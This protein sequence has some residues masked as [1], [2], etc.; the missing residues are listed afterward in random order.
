MLVRSVT[1]ADVTELDVHLYLRDMP[2]LL[3]TV[4]RTAQ[5]A[6][7]VRAFVSAHKSP[8]D[9]PREKQVSQRISQGRIVSS[10]II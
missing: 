5:C 6:E 2:A 10:L 3:P 7:C 1:T 9:V 8:S 4:C